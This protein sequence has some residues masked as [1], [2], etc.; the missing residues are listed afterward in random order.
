MCARGEI[1]V[2]CDQHQRGPELMIELLDQLHDSLARLPVE[3]AGR[4]IGEQNPRLVGEGPRKGDPLLLATR[5]LRRIVART[6]PQ[7]HALEKRRR[8]RP[9]GSAVLV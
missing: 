5:E 4:L 6:V 7:S 9:N 3:I 2:V 1:E 8:P